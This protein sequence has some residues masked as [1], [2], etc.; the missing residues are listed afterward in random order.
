MLIRFQQAEWRANSAG[1][2]SETYVWKTFIPV[3]SI[4][5]VTVQSAPD[6]VLVEGDDGSG[7]DMPTGTSQ[8]TRTSRKRA[9]ELGAE[10][11]ELWEVECVESN[12]VGI[13]NFGTWRSKPT[14]SMRRS[15]VTRQDVV[16]TAVILGIYGIVLAVVHS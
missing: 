16:S 1:L 12:P 11:A 7:L 15:A 2:V 5:R 3:A 13:D 14:G 9:L 6:R 8:T 10:L 4:R